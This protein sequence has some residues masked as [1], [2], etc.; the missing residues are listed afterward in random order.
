VSKISL[1]PD[2]SGSGIFTI[3]SPNSNTNRTLTLPDD[4]GTLALAGAVPDKIEEGDSKVEVTD[5]GTGKVETVACDHYD[6][7]SNETVRI[8][9]SRG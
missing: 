2:A 7:R 6:G 1:A 9:S 3:A 5:A 8:D 4:T